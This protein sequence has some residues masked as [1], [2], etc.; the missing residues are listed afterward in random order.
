MNL[1][2]CPS[3]K[4][5]IDVDNPLLPAGFFC[6]KCSC[7]WTWLIDLLREAKAPGFR[8]GAG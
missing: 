7:R 2:P 4:G 5:K 1:P 6:T 8:D 3:C